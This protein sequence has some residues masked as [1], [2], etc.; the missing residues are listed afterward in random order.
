[1]TS[2]I[3]TQQWIVA[4]AMAVA[5]A[6]AAPAHAQPPEPQEPYKPT[7][8]QAGKDVIW[9]PT[10]PDL[11]ELM[12]DIAKVGPGDLVMDLG[13]GDGRNIIAAAKRG[14]RG[15]GVEY[16][17][18]LVEY[19][20]RTAEAEGVG[21]LAKFV[22]EDMY[23]ADISEA[24]VLALFL[25]PSNLEKMTPRFLAMK[26]GS[27]IVLNTFAIPEWEADQT[28]EVGG[29]C[30]S[31]CTA[32]LWIVPAQVHGRW[33]VEGGSVLA[34]DQT[35]QKVMGTLGANGESAPVAGSLRGDQIR[36]TAGSAEYTAHVAGDRMQGTVVRGGD[37]APFAATRQQ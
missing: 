24:T 30:E 21:T 37:E 10:P 33:A 15:I 29:D 35:F 27:R 26:P 36:F 17:D 14:A 5:I 11:V 32:L 19:S 22:K 28:A 8:G 34:I 7:V 16:N 18:D 3:R 31:W 6:G 20:A 12:L 25:L 13:S 9:V 4:A 1:V 23:T 2:L